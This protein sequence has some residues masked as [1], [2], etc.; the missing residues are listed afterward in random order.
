MRFVISILILLISFNV[1]GQEGKL[2]FTRIDTSCH[3]N[4]ETKAFLD[5]FYFDLPDISK[6]L[7]K[8]HIRVS[9]VGK[10]VDLFSKDNKT[11]NGILTNYVIQ[12]LSV[13]SNNRKVN[14]KN[15]SDKIIVQKVFLDSVNCSLVAQEVI[16]S[17]Q[18][19]LPSLSGM[20]S[21]CGKVKFTFKIGDF[22]QE[23]D[24]SC[25]YFVKES[26]SE[27]AIVDSNLKLLRQKLNLETPYNF[28]SLIKP[29]K[30][31]YSYSNGD[32]NVLSVDYRPLF[33]N[34]RKSRLFNKKSK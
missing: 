16:K 18:V 27:K 15:N 21:D 29:G 23:Q 20:G 34:R 30:I 17:G 26:I 5:S 2:R 8:T 7:Y 13:Q 28:L 12:S 4:S 32:Q 1:F 11:Y 6:S 33:Y 31:V 14:S 24:F 10:Y 3:Y 22:Y 9:L 19:R 25:M